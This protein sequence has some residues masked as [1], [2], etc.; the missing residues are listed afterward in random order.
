MP[1]PVLLLP[2]LPWHVWAA[3]QYCQE[4]SLCGGHPRSYPDSA[5]CCVRHPGQFVYRMLPF[6]QMLFG[7]FLLLLLVLVWVGVVWVGPE[8]ISWLPPFCQS[9]YG[10]QRADP[11]GLGEGNPQRVHYSELQRYARYPDFDFVSYVPQLLLRPSFVGSPFGVFGCALHLPDGILVVLVTGFFGVGVALAQFRV[12]CDV[13]ANGLSSWLRLQHAC[14]FSLCRSLSY[15]VN[16]CQVWRPILLV[17]L[18]LLFLVL[19]DQPIVVSV[20]WLDAPPR[21]PGLLDRVVWVRTLLGR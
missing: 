2:V 20:I 17:Y 7:P 18:I 4:G 9:Q 15:L 13:L 14:V 11:Y 19:L 12:L 21:C 6:G 3:E 10:D 8:Q 1:L 5:F 16:P